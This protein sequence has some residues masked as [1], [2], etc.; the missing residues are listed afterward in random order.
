MRQAVILEPADL[1]A[2]KDGTPLT[3]SVGGVE[4]SLMMARS[5]TRV[6][7]SGPPVL[8]SFTK[9]FA[10]STRFTNKTNGTRTQ[11]TDAQ[12]RKILR[13]Y[14]KTKFKTAWLE[15]HHLHH[16]M[17]VNWRKILKSRGA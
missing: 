5:A 17:I 12:R 10:R 1:A 13:I 2:L 11:Y 15:R 8:N 9:A 3:L 7:P 14:D 16:S 4:V 6:V